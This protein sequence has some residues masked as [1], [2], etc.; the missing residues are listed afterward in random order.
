MC[1]R[2]PTHIYYDMSSNKQLEKN[3]SSEMSQPLYSLVD[4]KQMEYDDAI[5]PDN[6]EQY[7]PK[8]Y[9]VVPLYGIPVQQDEPPAYVA[10]ADEELELS[11]KLE[12]LPLPVTAARTLN[13]EQKQQRVRNA[14]LYRLIVV[15][16]FY[17][18]YSGGCGD[19][20]EETGLP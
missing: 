19:G 5:D 13:E 20:Q 3:T 6:M 7:E 17:L 1:M 10:N 11:E 2:R 9:K 16:L 15:L 14:R 8:I 18:L 12:G 4:F